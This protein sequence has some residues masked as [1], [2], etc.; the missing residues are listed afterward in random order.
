MRLLAAVMLA[1]LLLPLT[2][3]AQDGGGLESPVLDRVDITG[4]QRV[5]REAIRVQL[6]AQPGTRLNEE[7]VDGDIRALY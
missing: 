6:R 3:T 7:T 4:N 1:G 5:E 2:A